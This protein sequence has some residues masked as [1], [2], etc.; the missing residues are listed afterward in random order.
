MNNLHQV[1]A[2]FC[3]C[4]LAVLPAVPAS[5]TENHTLE[6]YIDQVIQHNPR[7]AAY[8]AQRDAAVA[9]NRT[10]LSLPDPEVEFAWFWASDRGWRYDISASQGFDFG[11]LLGSKRKLAKSRNALAEIEYHQAEQLVRLGTAQLL[12]RISAANL[13]RDELLKRQQQIVHHDSTMQRLLAKGEVSRFERNKTQV[14][15]ADYEAMLARE[16]VSRQMLLAELRGM[17]C[18]LDAA[19]FRIDEAGLVA[20][21]RGIGVTEGTSGDTQIAAAQQR[22]RIA[23]DEIRGAR[24]G[25][26]P[27]F[28][29]GYVSEN[30]A[31]SSFRGIGLNVSVPLWSARSN[32]RRAKAERAAAAAET[33][34]TIAEL[35]SQ[36]EILRIRTTMLKDIS[37]RTAKS[38][39]AT[40]PTEM[41]HK[42][43]HA[44]EMSLTDYLLEVE[45]SYTLYDKYLEANA[46]YLEALAELLVLGGE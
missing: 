9:G 21:L 2:K 10:G 5:A 29:V 28:S 14:L 24:H 15:V 38:H 25:A 1:F 19:N 40:S 41:L 43:L 11:V 4:V 31:Y 46:E 32:I 22:E 18:E 44:G 12:C 34:A 8:R 37:L 35:E 36:R 20:A 13:R 42:A 45:N 33:A 23:E 30:E 17:G 6:A 39:A 7:L 3:L 26:L 27:S 16:E